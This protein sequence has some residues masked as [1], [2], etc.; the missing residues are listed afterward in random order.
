MNKVIF[1][2]VHSAGRSQMAAAFFNA[3]SNGSKARALSAGTDPGERV[4]PEVVAVMKE[5]GIDLS[6]AKPQRLTSELARGAGLLVTMGCGDECPVV[7]GARRDDWLLPD[8]KGKSLDEV[9]R[10]R[11]DIRRRVRE[12]VE[13]EGS[14]AARAVEIRRALSGDRASVENLLRTSGLPLEGVQEHFGSFVVATS[15]SRVVGTAG[16]ELYGESAL[17]RSVAV[18]SDFRGTGVGTRLTDAALALAA[19][20]GATSVSLLT[21]TAAPFFS[22]RGFAVVPWSALP[23]NLSASSELTGACPTTATAMH[24]PLRA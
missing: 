7:P 21:T 9:R 24:R 19:A 10:I 5:V 1:A 6:N 23:S 15:D 2:C 3:I 4:H 14:L 13:R 12:L 8:P 11:D 22:A 18:D 16:V 17:L 20:A